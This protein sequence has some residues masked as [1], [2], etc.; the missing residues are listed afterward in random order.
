MGEHVSSSSATGT[1]A[2]GAWGDQGDGTYQNPILPGDYSDL[3]AIRT[4][5]DF[6][7][8]SS[9]FQFSPGIVV[10]HSKD[11]VNW[12]ILGHAVAGTSYRSQSLPP[13]AQFSQY[14]PRLACG[15]LMATTRPRE[16]ITIGKIAENTASGTNAASSKST[17]LGEL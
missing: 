15:V 2:M 10:L 17:R 5:D 9:T 7:A 11:L 4:G 3:D 12:S 14:H 1:P 8:I 6:Y 16:T 13:D